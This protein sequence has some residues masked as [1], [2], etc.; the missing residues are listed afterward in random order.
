MTRLPFFIL[1][2]LLGL[3]TNLGT[4]RAVGPV[5]LSDNKRSF[6]DE[7]GQP[8]LF[9]G[10]TAWELGHRL[11]H[12]EAEY[13]FR[14]RRDQ[15][16][17]V[18]M[19]LALPWELTT[20]DIHG[21]QALLDNDPLRPNERWFQQLDWLLKRANDF[22]LVVALLPAN[23]GPLR[24][25]A[26]SPLT[27]SNARAYGRWIGKRYRNVSNL[28]WINGGDSSVQREKVED[29]WRELALGVKESDPNHLMG[30]HIASGSSSRDV[31]NS[32]AW[33][34]FHM[35][36]TWNRP[37]A[38]YPSVLRDYRAT[39]ILPVG[40][41]EGAYE[42]GPQYG[43]PVTP[44]V[45][46]KQAWWAFLAGGY[47]IYGHTSVWN[48][49]RFTK[50]ATVPW[51]DALHSPGARDM[52]AL[53]RV[54]RECRWWELE[55]DQDIFADGA[56]SGINVNAAA[57]AHDGSRIIA[58]FAAPHPAR[59]RLDG[60]AAAPGAQGFW[61]DPRS[62]ART[63]IGAVPTREVRSFTPPEGFED[64]V[65]LIESGPH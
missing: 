16:F 23:S 22:G 60:L 51:K 57:R 52:Q 64:A 33:L 9:L 54:L 40:L 42:D 48:F 38:A 28:I 31:F 20:R 30:F 25:E 32:D 13:Y 47:H 29:A 5:R 19:V 6:V 55:P 39:P 24:G 27:R 50:E 14:A 21:E 62:G 44:L 17:T 7:H 36:Q 56:G 11:T 15:G 41:G 53:G 65:L 1:V 59:L 46:R 58:Y 2:L 4:A 37:E 43:F 18:L 34:D 10:D 3:W 26:T 63:A 61:I 49:G 45:I 35:L 8:F 12:A